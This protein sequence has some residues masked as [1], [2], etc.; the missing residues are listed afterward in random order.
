MG[1]L[2]ILAIAPDTGSPDDLMSL[3]HPTVGNLLHVPAYGILGG[4]WIL[5]LR[6]LGLVK[7][8]AIGVTLAVCVLY[9]AALEFVQV[10]VPG[11]FVSVWDVLAN[12]AGVVIVCA[13]YAAGGLANRT[14]AH[15]EKP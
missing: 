13:W 1:L 5:I 6:G 12:L 8:R 15:N 3:I 4:L 11:R 2:F 10:D 7:S 14:T 9:G